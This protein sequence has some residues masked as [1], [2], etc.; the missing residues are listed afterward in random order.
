MDTGNESK[1]I[2]IAFLDT[3]A[4]VAYFI[5]KEIGYKNMQDLV[6]NQI[7][8]VLHISVLSI[9]E[10]INTLKSRITNE[11]S[12]KRIIYVFTVYLRQNFRVLELPKEITKLCSFMSY[13]RDNIKNWAHGN[14]VDAFLAATMEV[15]L[16]DFVEESTP[17]LVSTDKDFCKGI[18]KKD[19]LAY[20]PS[21]ESFKNFM[22]N[23]LS[24]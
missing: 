22:N 4:V 7:D 12:L 13:V 14:S 23:K 15:H 6:N 19:Y 2:R 8:V 17:F 20:N 1:P 5:Q 11:E 3:S 18:R 24:S 9:G 10:I 21:E 16:K